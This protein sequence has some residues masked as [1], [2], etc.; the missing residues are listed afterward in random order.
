MPVGAG[1]LD[2]GEE[3]RWR[4]NVGRGWVEGVARGAGVGLREFEV[5]GE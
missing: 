2:A 4:V 1:G 3:E 5:L